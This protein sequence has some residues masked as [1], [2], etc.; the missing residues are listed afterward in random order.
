MSD[1]HFARPKTPELHAPF[2]IIKPGIDLG[3]KIGSRNDDAIFA[4]EAGS[5]SFS[6]FH[7]H[8]SSRPVWTKIYRLFRQISPS[9]GNRPIW[10]G[11][12][13]SNPHDLRHG[14]L[15]P[16]RLPIPP[17]P[18]RVGATRRAYII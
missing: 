3:F 17:R 4:L 11:R 16:A 2:E 10:C 1:R 15:S 5:G 9:R 7:R 18:R 8:Y 14:I 13:D 6:Y 12:S